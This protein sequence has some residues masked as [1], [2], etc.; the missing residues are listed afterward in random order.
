MD[1]RRR[2]DRL[3]KKKAK[4]KAIVADKKKLGLCQ[5]TLSKSAA[6][7]IAQRS[8]L[9]ECLVGKVLFEQ[10]LGTILISRKTPDRHIG[11]GVFLLDVYCLG[12]KNAFFCWLPYNE[13]PSLK[14]KISQHE[15]LENIDPSCAFKLIEECVEYAKNLGFSPHKDYT[16]LKKLFSDID[17]AGCARKFEFG[18]DG[19]PF[20]ICGPNE[21]PERSKQII[22]TLAKKCGVGN[23]DFM[24]TVLGVEL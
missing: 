20:Y 17:P 7:A 15:G 5:E 12:V 8:P 23:F 2:Q 6:I 9:Y 13:Y 10:G 11:A 22:N 16:L 14:N 21:S 19:K 3:A 1:Q 4:R 18:K 24:T